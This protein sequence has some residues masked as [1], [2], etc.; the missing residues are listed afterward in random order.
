MAVD[1]HDDT[2]VVKEN[3]GERDLMMGITV[4]AVMAFGAI[5]LVIIFSLT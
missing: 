4:G 1:T 3:I 2:P 5:A